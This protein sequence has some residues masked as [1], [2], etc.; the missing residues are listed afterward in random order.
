MSAKCETPQA[1]D[2]AWEA[3]QP[4]NIKSRAQNQQG[5]IN[6]ETPQNFIQRDGSCIRWEVEQDTSAKPAQTG[7]M[8]CKGNLGKILFIHP[9]SVIFNFLPRKCHHRCPALFRFDG[10]GKQKD[11]TIRYGIRHIQVWSMSLSHV[12][13][14]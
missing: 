10:E 2:G 12:K 13:M 14:I 5:K 7:T 8:Q 3:V 11:A 6:K 4:G 1:V 9:C